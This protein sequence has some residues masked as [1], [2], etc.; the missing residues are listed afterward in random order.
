MAMYTKIENEKEM[1]RVMEVTLESVI[2]GVLHHKSSF[3][4]VKSVLHN[5]FYCIF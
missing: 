3:S 1:S 5:A 4:T 2:C